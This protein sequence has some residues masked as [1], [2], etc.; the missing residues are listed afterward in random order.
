MFLPPRS[1]TEPAVFSPAVSS[2][3]T[4]V[5][6]RA[7]MAP[8]S[9]ASVGTM[10]N[11]V[12][13]V[14]VRLTVLSML[15]ITVGAVGC[16]SGTTVG[17]TSYAGVTGTTGGSTGIVNVTSQGGSTSTGQDGAVTDG[18]TTASPDALCQPE[19]LSNAIEFAMC[20]SLSSFCICYL[21]T[22][23]PVPDGAVIDSNAFDVIVDSEGRVVDNTGL[24]GTA[25]QAWLDSLADDRW[26]CLAGQT[27][28]YIVE[29]GG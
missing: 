26:P 14:F 2:Y 21:V 18:Q 11:R 5:V 8:A 16:S 9:R 27:I 10:L 19:V 23:L 15:V 25:K 29:I 24:Y 28:Q 13:C 20:G 17:M 1:S 4:L 6:E 22:P 3:T 7:S 12:C